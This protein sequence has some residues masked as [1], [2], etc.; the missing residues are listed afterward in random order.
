MSF[1]SVYF[2]VYSSI[3]D[4][5]YYFKFRNDKLKQIKRNK[6]LFRKYCTILPKYLTEATFV[7]VGANDGIT[8][9]PCSD[10]LIAN[11]KWKGL[12]IEPQKKFIKELKKNFN[13]S[14][15]FKVEQIGVSS[16]EGEKIFY[17]VGDHAKEDAK[18]FKPFVFLIASFDK[19]HILKH[20]DGRLEPYI[21][22]E[23]IKTDTLQ[24]I[25]LNN[26]ISDF[27]L[28]H[29]DAEGHDLVVLKSMDL[30]VYTP[31]LIYIEYSHLSDSD[32]IELLNHLQ[33]QGYTVYDCGIDY[34]AI[35]KKKYTK[36]M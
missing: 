9:D 30:S 33:N 1:S 28:L 32:N 25:L 4:V 24:N 34:F 23:K 7:K 6:Q 27:Q 31:T 13:D 21:I 17:Y 20:S 26:N 11:L 5:Y 19:S 10:I 22:E 16:K 14:Q 15:R 29:I 35:N 36:L 18:G 12:L 8:F 2:Y 3:A